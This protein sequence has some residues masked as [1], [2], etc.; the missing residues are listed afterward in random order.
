M[1]QHG[2]CQRAPRAIAHETSPRPPLTARR[3]GQDRPR[4]PRRGT[5]VR[6]G[7]ALPE[8]WRL[9]DRRGAL[10]DREPPQ[11]RLARGAPVLRARRRALR[12][13]A[14]AEPSITRAARRA[15]ARSRGDRLRLL[16]RRRDRG[17]QELRARDLHGAR[18]RR[19]RR[20]TRGGGAAQHGALDRLPHRAH[21]AAPA[22]HPAAAERRARG[23]VGRRAPP[24]PVPPGHRVASPPPRGRRTAVR[25]GALHAAPRADRARVRCGRVAARSLAARRPVR[26]ALPG[27]RVVGRS[28]RG[29]P[30]CALRRRPRKA[31]ADRGRGNAAL[32]EDSCRPPRRPHARDRHAVHRRG[33][34]DAAVR[35]DERDGVLRPLD[36]DPRGR[37]RAAR[38]TAALR[39]AGARAARERDR[40]LREAGGARPPRQRSADARRA[41][42]RSRLRRSG[43]SDRHRAA[44]ARRRDRELDQHRG[45]SSAS[46]R[47]RRRQHRLA[48]RGRVPDLRPRARPCHRAWAREG[49]GRDRWRAGARRA[50]RH[51]SVRPHPYRAA[52][53]AP[54][55]HRQDDRGL[56][57]APPP[58]GLLVDRETSSS[59]RPPTRAS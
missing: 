36:R 17:H 19:D 1:H 44:R 41:A 57:R 9:G 59:S 4:D 53:A 26:G 7:D 52:G 11:A 27:S 14:R 6:C 25:R 32:P 3:H 55:V 45:A 21:A 20:H 12:G 29:L 31:R 28:P 39:S 54:R 42:P 47:A 38:A 37:A 34:V 49:S 48:T 35:D 2:R 8:R 24:H 22:R 5:A 15:A 16:G 33:G 56:G 18:R 46:L 43:D 23:H 51:R 40:V 50:S 30:D 58:Q 13:R 10:R